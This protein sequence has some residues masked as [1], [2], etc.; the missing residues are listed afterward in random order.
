MS[1]FNNRIL[2]LGGKDY[3]VETLKK[4]K[5]SYFQVQMKDDLTEL[6]LNNASELIIVE[7]FDES[8]IFELVSSLAKSESFSAVV[9]FAETHQELGAKIAEALNIASNCSKE[10]VIFSCDKLK[11]REKLAQSN[12]RQARFISV[13]SQKDLEVF[14]EELNKPII[15]KPSNSSGSLG[16]AKVDL[17]NYKQAYA[18]LSETFSELIAEEFIGG[19]EFSI[20]CLSKEGEHE[21]L[22][23]TEKFT[24]G[25]PGF[26]ETGHMQPALISPSVRDE[27]ERVVFQLL[28]TIGHQTGPSHTELKVEDNQVYIIETHVRNGG[29]NIWE[30]T[31]LTTGCNMFEEMFCHLLSLPQPSRNKQFD[32][33]AIRFFMPDEEVKDTELLGEKYPLYKIHMEDQLDETISVANSSCDRTGYA[34]F[35]ENDEKKIRQVM[36][37]LNYLNSKKSESI[38]TKW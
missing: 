5:V 11:M 33:V 14:L 25:A 26:I 24:T 20:E 18:R 13:K 30:L 12:M 28:T 32:S 17:T 1:E 27:I 22:A 37:E 3:H 8:K 6:Q 15:L 10:A 4:L 35:A 29:D 7:S 9:A 2:V 34:I 21:L 38:G 31:L 23:V 16:V 36:S 19:Q